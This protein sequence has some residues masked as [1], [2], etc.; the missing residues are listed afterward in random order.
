MWPAGLFGLHGEVNSSGDE[1]K[2][3][4]VLSNDIFVNAL[5]NSVRWSPS[6]AIT[7]GSS[8]ARRNARASRDG[9]LGAEEQIVD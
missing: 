5:K 6:C 7:R 8:R 9:C 3:L 1:Q 2:K 4:D